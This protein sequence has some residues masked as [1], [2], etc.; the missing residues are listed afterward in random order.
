MTL[1]IVLVQKRIKTLPKGYL[2]FS[3]MVLFLRGIQPQGIKI[4][5][6]VLTCSMYFYNQALAGIKKDGDISKKHDDDFI[7]LHKRNEI[8]LREWKN[9][10]Q[11]AEEFYVDDEK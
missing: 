10:F 11:K 6:S 7:M 2:T 9:R 3:T 5:I 8:A 4:L 1:F